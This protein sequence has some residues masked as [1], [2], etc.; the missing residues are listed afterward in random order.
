[1]VYFHYHN[2]KKGLGFMALIQVNFVSSALKR[3]VPIQVILPVDKIFGEAD[4]NVSP[5]PFKTLYLL[6]GLLGNYTDW[7][8]N[9]RI[10]QW[11]EAKNLAVVMPSGDNSFYI[12]QPTPNNDYGDF[13]GRELVQITR[14]M[15]PLSHKREDTFIAG[16][17][18]GGFGA[19]RNGLVYGETF[20]YIAG[21]SS[22][23]HIFE[24]PFDAPGRCLM[25]EDRVFGDL[26]TASRTNKNPRVALDQLK[27]RNAPLPK[28]YMACGLQDRLLASNRTL[29][30]YFLENGIS[31][32]YQEAVGDHNW[33][34]WN[35]Q[36]QKVLEWLPLEDAQ[37]GLNS[38]NVSAAPK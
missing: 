6:H 29:K 4:E 18:M 34:F 15:F 10:L 28:I 9:T 22:A 37:E 38:G 12:D 33:D 17:S 26:P 24:M 13:I 2:V 30:D 11:A 20:G 23:T 3:T 31:L 16:L 5:A 19:I 21:L 8:S 32:T 35:D 7:V 25:N 27:Q 14:K 1:M 36:I